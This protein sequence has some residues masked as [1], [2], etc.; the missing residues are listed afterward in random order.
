MINS[1]ESWSRELLVQCR[2]LPPYVLYITRCYNK[3]VAFHILGYPI[4]CAFV[5]NNQFQD[6]NLVSA[7]SL[8]TRNTNAS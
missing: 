5:R 3:C 8:H 7:Q 6:H 1:I 2:F 4:L